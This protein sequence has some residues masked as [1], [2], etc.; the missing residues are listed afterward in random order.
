MKKRN[1]LNL[2]LSMG[3]AIGFLSVFAT[4][5]SG[6][7]ARLNVKAD[8]DKDKETTKNESE[9]KSSRSTVETQTY[10]LNIQVSNTIKQEDSFD[11][12][13]YFLSRSIDSKGKKGDPIL[14]AKDKTSLTIGGQKRVSH[15]V[16]SKTLKNSESKK[17]SGSSKSSGPAKSFSGS[18]YAGYVVLVRQDG[19]ILAKYSN[20]SKFTTEEWLEKLEGSVQKSSGMSSLSSS[21]KKKRKKKKK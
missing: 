12:E 10:T 2:M 8:L 18:V 5:A 4:S 9:K 3:L 13:W 1:S 7:A 19:K 14:C 17:S 21:D 20:E 6:A 15:E 11:L 16:V